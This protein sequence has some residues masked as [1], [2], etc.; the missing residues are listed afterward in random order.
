MADPDDLLIHPD[1]LI[2]PVGRLSVEIRRRLNAED[3][4]FTVSRRRSRR[5]SSVIDS[6]SARLLEQFRT[7]HT[8]AEAV[9]EEARITGLEPE[10]LL[11]SASGVL[12]ELFERGILVR[13][14][15]ATSD[16]PRLQRGDDF[17][18]AEVLRLI[19]RMEDTEVYLI[20]W[21]RRTA[22]LKWIRKNEGRW[23]GR[24]RRETEILGR[25]SDSGVTPELLETG[26]EQGCPFLILEHFPGVDAETATRPLA[27]RGRYRE[28]REWAVRLVS[29]YATLHRA[30]IVHGDV[31][32]RNIL[33][34]REGVMRL[35]DF[36]FGQLVSHPEPATPG[37][38]AFYFSPELAA[39][40]IAGASFAPSRES[41]QYS[42][43]AMLFRL[44][45]G[46]HYCAFQLNRAGLLRQVLD[47][48]PIAAPEGSWSDLEGVLH[49]ALAKDPAERFGDL[50]GLAA[51]LTSL[52]PPPAAPA[53]G[54]IGTGFAECYRA[55]IRDSAPGGS[56][57]TEDM[58]APFSS[59][60]FG[61]AG[62]A[63]ALLR[64]A[65]ALGDGELLAAAEIWSRRAARR[66]GERGAFE[67]PELGLV[68]ERI[69]YRSP[70]HN[71]SGV[72][73]V[74]AMIA[75]A[76]GAESR[77]K[78]ALQ[79][80]LETSALP[81]AGPDLALGDAGTLLAC[82]FLLAR[83]PNP[84][85]PLRQGLLALG[86]ELAAGLFR[87]ADLGESPQRAPGFLGMAHGW[88][89]CLFAALMWAR[90]TR[91]P[92]APFLLGQLDE[93]AALGRPRGR[94]RCWPVRLAK[95]EEALTGW[96]HGSAG[97]VLLFNLAAELTADSRYHELADDA[98]WDAWD[99]GS[100]TASLCCGLVGRAYAL[101]SRHR[102]SGDPGWRRRA[103]DLT[104][105]A[106]RR[107]QFGDAHRR[108]LYKGQLALSM[109]SAEV[110]R[111]SSVD[112]PCVEDS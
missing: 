87:H 31:H 89:G 20:E 83:T 94:G 1:V 26:E 91:A 51:A 16:Q 100:I 8:L 55:L 5:P 78:A 22:V 67:C 63:F 12:Q 45:F 90:A 99:D 77:Q 7:P 9:A 43:A 72:Y 68:P 29:L 108:S 80:F 96:C 19:H 69:G 84:R 41:E 37:G 34:D 105:R 47:A 82:A 98:A 30:G 17:Q 4:D 44:L 66:I 86:D 24:F 23:L 13:A 102:S 6:A 93:L 39:A 64:M 49:R 71:A 60:K 57:L 58:P 28:E 65:D 106:A 107:G 52:D 97:Y 14:S 101:L 70:F 110:D 92:P 76:Q 53:I 56:W 11:A 112:F 74:E 15:L 61:A 59:V 73:W 75:A 46:V 81:G 48:E 40:E 62:V 27:A 103:E 33:V 25:L 3:S 21:H 42:L 54:R 38:V 18:G 10:T 88:T 32:P 104:Y 85:Q 109:L 2:Q 111:G 95:P 79:G 36:G 35:I 50:D